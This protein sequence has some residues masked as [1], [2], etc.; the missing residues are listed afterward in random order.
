MPRAAGGPPRVQRQ[1]GAVS[2]YRG[3]QRLAPPTPAAHG[4]A[5]TLGP[6]HVC[7]EASAAVRGG[8]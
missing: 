6:G 4:P 2:V 8:V 7:G 1:R 3:G 5:L